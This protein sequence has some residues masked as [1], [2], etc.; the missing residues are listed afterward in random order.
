M[1]ILTTLW[2]EFTIIPVLWVVVIVLYFSWEQGRGGSRGIE[3][4]RAG[5]RGRNIYRQMIKLCRRRIVLH[6]C[7][8]RVQ[9]SWA[10]NYYRKLKT[11]L[12]CSDENWRDATEWGSSRVEFYY[13]I[14]L[15]FTIFYLPKCQPLTPRRSCSCTTYVWKHHIMS[16]QSLACIYRPFRIP[17]RVGTGLARPGHLLV[18]EIKMTRARD[19]K[20]W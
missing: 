2:S 8:D 18:T 7:S 16:V 1:C 10:T 6:S 19:L 15:W 4:S 3:K 11:G 9:S 5:E 13:F 12:S 17:C 20:K 14:P